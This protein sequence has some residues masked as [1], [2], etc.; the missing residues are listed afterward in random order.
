MAEGQKL[1]TWGHNGRG[2]RRE[3]SAQLVVERGKDGQIVLGGLSSPLKMEGGEAQSG[4]LPGQGMVQV[5]KQDQR[6]D[7][8]NCLGWESHRDG[9]GQRSVR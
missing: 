4:G 1:A 8:G 6:R 3:G 2:L 7:V 9:L 5:V